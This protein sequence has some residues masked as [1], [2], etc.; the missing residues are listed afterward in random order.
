MI[1]TI[2]N[3]AIWYSLYHIE[4]YDK[5]TH[6]IFGFGNSTTRLSIFEFCFEDFEGSGRLQIESETQ[7]IALDD[8]PHISWSMGHDAY[9]II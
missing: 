6:T 7:V 9:Y 3:G 2:L 5:E 8:D 4:P 1:W